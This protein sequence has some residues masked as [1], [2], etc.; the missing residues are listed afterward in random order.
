MTGKGKEPARDP[1]PERYHPKPFRK[2]GN[3]YGTKGPWWICCKNPNKND[4][5]CCERVLI[6]TAHVSKTSEQRRDPRSKVVH[7]R[8]PKNEEAKKKNQERRRPRNT[9]EAVI[10]LLSMARSLDGHNADKKGWPMHRKDRPG[11]VYILKG[12]SEGCVKVGRAI[13]T[14]GRVDQ[15]KTAD[16]HIKILQQTYSDDHK[17]AE[18]LAQHMLDR[19]RK[20]RNGPGQE[21]FNIDF[22]LAKL[23]V[24]TAVFYVDNLPLE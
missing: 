3:Q 21:W 13:K 20:V 18:V 23:A 19:Y 24:A 2:Q 11:Y 22:H 9:Q 6:E 8:K 4:P 16:P 14:E 12:A 7:P 15:F 5:G 1:V 17:R 10:S